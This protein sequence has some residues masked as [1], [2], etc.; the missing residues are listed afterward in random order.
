MIEEERS[1]PISLLP[2]GP[3]RCTVVSREGVTV[4]EAVQP[5]RLSLCAAY[6]SSLMTRS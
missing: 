1:L 2:F 6:L 3:H 5:C 4:Q